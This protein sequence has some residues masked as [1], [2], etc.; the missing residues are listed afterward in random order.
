MPSQSIDHL[1]GI[2]DN[3]CQSHPNNKVEKHVELA[4]EYI[5]SFGAAMVPGLACTSLFVLHVLAKCYA[6]CPKA[7][8]NNDTLVNIVNAHF[9]GYK[10]VSLLF[11]TIST[12]SNID[13]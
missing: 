11:S 1:C 4:M 10:E 7:R 6:I 3:E 9:F 12:T 8:Q 5:A 2:C 13:V